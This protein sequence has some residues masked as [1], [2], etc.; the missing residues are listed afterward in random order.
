MF[1]NFAEAST[2]PFAVQRAPDGALLPAAEKPE[3]EVKEREQEKGRASEKR[4][5][6]PQVRGGAKQGAGE[7]PVKA[8]TV[9]KV[10]VLRPLRPPPCRLRMRPEW[11]MDKVELANF[12]AA[13]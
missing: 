11:E 9:W 10:G 8:S 5:A 1:V 7:R 12:V 4:R 2:G 3:K 13:G 6:H